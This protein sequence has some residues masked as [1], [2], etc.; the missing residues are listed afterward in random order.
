[1]QIPSLFR[2][3]AATMLAVGGAMAHAQD[4]GG[5]HPLTRAEVQNEL[6]RLEAAGY[7]PHRDNA[8]YPADL[9]AAEQRLQALRQGNPL[10]M[11]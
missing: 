11:N 8:D 4:I 5:N 2:M 9:Q 1:M 7:D 3:F 6:A 10:T